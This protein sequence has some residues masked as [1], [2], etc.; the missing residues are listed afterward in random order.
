MEKRHCKAKHLFSIPDL[1][2]KDPTLPKVNATGM[3]IIFP[4]VHFYTEAWWHIFFS[5]ASSDF[6]I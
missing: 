6:D 4:V 1:R 2:S 3:Y 5:G